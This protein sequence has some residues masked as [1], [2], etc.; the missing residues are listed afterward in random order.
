MLT[1]THLAITLFFVLILLESISNKTLFVAVALIS[2]LIPDIDS[3]FSSLGKKKVFRPLQFF[4]KHR[5]I[6]HSLTFLMII[7]GILISFY[8]I[9]AFPL[10]V[11]YGLHLF[12]DSFTKRGIELLYPLKK[13]FS[14]NI[15][16]GGFTDITLFL[17][18]SF[19]DLVFM[20][21]LI[22]SYL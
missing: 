10:F 2:T 17:I 22:Y 20:G 6:L 1:K 21:I 8:P 4:I 12:A 19:F 3:K 5:G 16:V 14:G 7:L 18:F 13:K 11:G 9:L 15:R